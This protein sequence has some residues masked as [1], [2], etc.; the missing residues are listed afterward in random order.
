MGRELQA[1]S[2]AH[3]EILIVKMAHVACVSHFRR[4]GS[5]APNIQALD[6]QEKVIPNSKKKGK[7]DSSSILQI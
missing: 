6:G 1:C 5:G 4:D 3:V 2:P 7:S